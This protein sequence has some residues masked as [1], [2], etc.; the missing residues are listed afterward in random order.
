VERDRTKSPWG[1]IQPLI[2]LLACMVAAAL[3]AVASAD[4]TFS[5]TAPVTIKDGDCATSIQTAALP[6]KSDIT[7]A[8]APAVLD[9]VE[10]VIHGLTYEFPKDIRMLLVD[11]GFRTVL[12]MHEAGN[13][14][15]ASSVTLTFDDAA[16]GPIPDPIVSGS[17]LPTQTEDGCANFAADDPFP[18]APPNPPNGP[19]GTTLASLDGTNPNGIWSL[20]IVDDASDGGPIGSIVG[21]ISGGWSVVFPSA[22]TPSGPGSSP[23]T[24]PGPPASTP[25][26]TGKRCKKKQPHRAISA[27][28]CKKRK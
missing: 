26:S 22:P 12:L 17:Y 28:K 3:P 10:V 25:P 6:F 9:D 23:G 13:S 24:Q 27:K 1:A 16:L 15:S 14:G 19:Y 5:N 20:Y 21:S 11:P 4:Q 8:G 18:G 2:A 7:V